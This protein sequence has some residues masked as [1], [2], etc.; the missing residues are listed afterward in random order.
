MVESC[1]T[2]VHHE[3]SVHDFPC[4]YCEVYAGIDDVL[5]TEYVRRNMTNADHIRSMSDEELIDLFGFQS[6]CSYVQYNYPKHCEKQ[7][8]CKR[9]LNEWL[10]EPWEEDDA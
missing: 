9:C 1:T 6:I 8:A 4:R 7:G 3:K 2:C 10:Q 5:R